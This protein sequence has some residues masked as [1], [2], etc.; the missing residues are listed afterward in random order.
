M[1]IT[2][3]ALGYLLSVR[4]NEAL[5]RYSAQIYTIVVAFVSPVPFLLSYMLAFPILGMYAWLERNCGYL[6]TEVSTLGG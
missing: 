6:H 3:E 2:K 5:G 4:N 1:C